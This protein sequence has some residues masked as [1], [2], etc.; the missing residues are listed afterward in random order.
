MNKV[1]V[2][3]RKDDNDD[4]DVETFKDKEA[5][6]A[7]VME[8]KYGEDWEAQAADEEWDLYAEIQ[9]DLDSLWYGR[10][11]L[12]DDESWILKESEVQD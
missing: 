3:I 9:D 2:L 1:Y 4:M 11:V 7:K 12:D 10:E 6:I 8:R 5:A